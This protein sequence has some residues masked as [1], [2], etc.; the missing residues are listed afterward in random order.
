MPAN[1]ECACDPDKG[2]ITYTITST[3][4]VSFET[5]E[6]EDI[7]QVVFGP[8]GKMGENCRMLSIKNKWGTQLVM[9]AHDKATT[10]WYAPPGT[11][12]S[13]PATV[14]IDGSAGKSLTVRCVPAIDNQA[15][16]ENS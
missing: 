10:H 5:T 14:R 7:F 4:P 9:G 3:Q 1:G 8:C 13:G 11:E 16:K 6:G 2:T 15:T 12:I